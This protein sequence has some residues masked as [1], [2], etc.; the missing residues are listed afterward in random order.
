MRRYA[1]RGRQWDRLKDIL[2]GREGHVAARRRT[3]ACSSKPF[4]LF[5]FTAPAVPRREYLPE[6]FGDS[7]DDRLSALQ[8]MG[9]EAALF[10]RVFRLLG[11]RYTTTNT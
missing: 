4:F 2:P 6:R 7:K 1:L 10:E 8:T 9:Q 5:R 11:Q 3:I